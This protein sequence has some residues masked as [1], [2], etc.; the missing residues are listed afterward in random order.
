MAKKIQR[1]AAVK[2]GRVSK[3]L[4]QGAVWS[5]VQK[6]RRKIEPGLLKIISGIRRIE[7]R[8]KLIFLALIFVIISASVIKHFHTLH[9][10]PNVTKNF[11]LYI[12]DGDTF[13]KVEK[14]LTDNGCLLNYQ[15]FRRFARI[16]DYDVNIRPGAYA[17]EQGWS[18]NKLVNVL[19][20]G[21]QTP[22]M[23][24]FN[25]VRTREELA[26]KLARQ[27]QS[28]SVSFLT[29]FKNDSIALK[30]GF[31]AETLPALFIPNT[32]SFYWTTSPLG[33]LTRMKREYDLFRNEKRKQKAKG[34]GLT[35]EQ[36]ATLASIVQE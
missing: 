20:S 1:R 2:K 28:D 26:G 31:K 13:E 32:Y 11:R 22:V 14:Q 6:I 27:L 25:N 23:V 18:N 36:V 21:A 30:L 24:I 15:S 35:T 8:K 5:F 12:H 9:W 10:G 17:I 19:R 4:K 34:L 33:F 29:A 7:L 16:K 3:K